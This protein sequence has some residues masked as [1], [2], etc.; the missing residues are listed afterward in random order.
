[1]QRRLL[2][3]L[4]WDMDGT[5]IDSTRQVPAAF[6]A[7]IED[8]EGLLVEPDTVVQ[9][10]NVG[11]PEAILKHLLGRE[12]ND[13]E[14]EAYYNHLKKA[15]VEPYPG[16]RDALA[17]LHK[18]VPVAVFTGASVRSAEILLAS[19][20]LSDLVP[21]IVGGDEVAQP[22]PA[23]DG[24]FEACRR[25]QCHPGR[26]AYIGDS[27]ADLA[28]ARRASAVAVAARWG[29]LYDPS[30]PADV[31]LAHPSDALSLLS[32]TIN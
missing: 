29:H 15:T 8:V 16:V 20:G 31:S 5:L 7:T 4:V 14:A 11:P 13:S 6:V 22:K 3:A 1:M 21:C 27:P 12:L 17:S 18:E 2:D 9:A 28:A 10:Y 26:T 19:A 32:M 24:I 23:P 30:A 25:L